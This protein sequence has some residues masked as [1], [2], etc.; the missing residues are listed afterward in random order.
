[1]WARSIVLV[2]TFCSSRNSKALPPTGLYMISVMRSAG[3]SRP[4]RNSNSVSALQVPLRRVRALI[5][6]VPLMVAGVVYVMVVAE[7]LPVWFSPT[8]RR[9]EF[10]KS[11]LPIPSLRP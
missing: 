8:S 7:M 6:V 1:M 2:P 5:K 4:L 10:R 3:A 9:T 11:E